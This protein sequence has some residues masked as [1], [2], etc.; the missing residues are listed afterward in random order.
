MSDW[1][2][3]INNVALKIVYYIV[4]IL[5]CTGGQTYS[6]DHVIILSSSDLVKFIGDKVGG[7]QQ[8]FSIKLNV[9]CK[10]GRPKE[11]KMKLIPHKEQHHQYV[12]LDACLHMPKRCSRHKWLVHFTHSHLQVCTVVTC[13]SREVCTASATT[14]IL[15]MDVPGGENLTQLSL[16]KVISHEL[17]LYKKVSRYRL[18][19]TVS[20]IVE[21]YIAD[22]SAVQFDWVE[23]PLPH[24]DHQEHSEPFVEIKRII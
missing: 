3:N 23:Q 22:C 17:L 14:P 21:G 20:L 8:E 24:E 1:S 13:D 10:C 9:N 15:P 12:S 11:V 7:V 2:T 18:K 6:G 4:S 19:V 16:S 5:C